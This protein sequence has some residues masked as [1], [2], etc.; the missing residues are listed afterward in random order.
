MAPR[1]G[2]R[3]LMQNKDVPQTVRDALQAMQLSQADTIGTD[4]HRRLCRREGWAYMETF[5]P[6]LVFTT[7]N[8][9]DT[10]Q[11]LLLE[12]QGY[13]VNF[14]VSQDTAKDLPKYRDMM[15]SLARDPVGQTVVFELIMRLFY[16]HVLGV[17]PE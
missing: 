5:G 15:C 14:D 8:L 2:I 6:P 16:L 1:S 7:P 9:A 11:V 17:R 10:K 4:G 13:K 12:V 3:E